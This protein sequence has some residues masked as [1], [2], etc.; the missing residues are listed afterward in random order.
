L[1]SILAWLKNSLCTPQG[2]ARDRPLMA[3][4]DGFLKSA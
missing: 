2:L 1:I 4:R 3:T